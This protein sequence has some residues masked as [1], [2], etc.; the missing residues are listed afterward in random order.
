MRSAPRVLHVAAEVHPLIK[1]GGLADVVGALPGALAAAGCDVRLLLP[2]YGDVLARWPAERVL[3]EV[4]APLGSLFGASRVRL[5]RGTLPNSTVPLY[6]LDAPWLYERGGNPYVNSDGLP[7]ADNHL[8]FGLLGHVAAQLAGG[9][10][11]PDW[12]ADILHA[13]DWHAALAPVCLRQH[14]ANAVRSV[15]TIHNLAFQGRFPLVAAFDLGLRAALLTPAAL[16]FHGDL[17]FM[18]GALVHA[19]AITTVSPTYAREILTVE[20]GEGLDGVLRDHAARLRG[21]LNGVDTTVW[22]SAHDGALTAR[23]GAADARQGK[24]LNRRAL[25]Q[26]CGLA[27]DETRPLLAVVGRLTGQKGLDL[28]LEAIESAAL[29]DVQLLVLGTGEAGLERAFSALAARQPQRI[30]AR[31]TFD[32]ALSHRVF[33][34][35]DMIVVPSRFEPCGLT[36]LY[37]L[38]YGTVPVVRRVG[39]LA[40]TVSDET[41]GE[42]GT[43]FVFEAP[44]A[45]ALRDTLVRALKVYREQPARWAALMRKGMAQEVS[46]ATPAAAYRELYQQVLL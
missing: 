4:G 24:A 43:G 45:H 13:H 33:A 22:D 2:A 36:Q 3:Q 31:I 35:A 29:D 40:D 37:G 10:L 18:K 46:W 5:L 23:Y 26:E 7:W 11:D 9:A 8:R 30:A 25:R 41:A 16:E 38:R 32:E 34:G 42:A 28:L 14:P 27:Q 19:D 12:R 39:G 21:I 17:S 20:Q 6:L 44:Y 1:T 15:F